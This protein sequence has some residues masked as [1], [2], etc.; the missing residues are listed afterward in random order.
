MRSRWPSAAGVRPRVLRPRPPRLMWLHW[1]AGFQPPAGL[2][3]SA[4][5]ASQGRRSRR[6]S[7]GTTRF[8]LRAL[9]AVPSLPID[10]FRRAAPGAAPAQRGR[11]FLGG[12]EGG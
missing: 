9:D 1:E 12:P 7:L 11:S 5:L 3:R 2:T 8:A 4:D 6:V 10:G